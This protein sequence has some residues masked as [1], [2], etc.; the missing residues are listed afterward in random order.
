LDEQALDEPA[1]FDATI[2]N[3][4]F[5]APP[6]EED[7]VRG[8]AT[9]LAIT[10]VLALSGM[11]APAPAQAGRLASNQYG[12]DPVNGRY[13]GYTPPYAYSAYYYGYPRDCGGAS[14]TFY[15]GPPYH[16]YRYGEPRYRWHPG[17]Y[18]R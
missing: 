13:P 17:G 15:F 9:V 8:M 4:R 6:Q 10:S 18:G 12:C 3:D 2:I 14:I 16:G 5:D 1:A 7:V 11:A